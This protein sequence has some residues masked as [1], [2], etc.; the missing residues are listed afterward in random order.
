M[1]E[2]AHIVD[3]D[4]NYIHLLEAVTDH[5]IC[6]ECDTTLP[7]DLTRTKSRS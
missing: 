7:A 6:C 1:A 4:L 5:Y 3:G 2:E